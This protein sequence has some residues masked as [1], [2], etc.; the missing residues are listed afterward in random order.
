[1]RV[2]AIIT[3]CLVLC[4]GIKNSIAQEKIDWEEDLLYAKAYLEIMH[5]RLFDFVTEEEF[6]NEF[7]YLLNNWQNLND[8]DIITLITAIFVKIQDGHTGISLFKSNDYI[9]G[10]FHYYPVWLYRFNDGYFVLYARNEYKELVGKKITRLG[11]LGICDAISRMIRFQTGDNRWGRVQYIPLIHE[12]MQ[13]AGVIGRE[14]DILVFQYENNKGESQEFKIERP[15]ALKDFYFPSKVFP[16][17]DPGVYAMND[18][19]VKALPLYLSRISEGGFAGNNYWYTWLPEQGAIYLQISNNTDKPDDPFDTFCT[20]MF[21]D[22]D[23]LNAGK[24]IVDV[25]LNGG[26]SHFEMPL[27][28]GI[29]ARPDIDSKGNLF[30]I[31]G[32]RTISASEHLTTL[33]ET[34]TN[35]V[36]V[37]EPTAARP[38]MSGSITGFTLPNSG[39]NCFTAKEYIQ[40]SEF[41]DFRLTTEPHVFSLLSSD[42]YKNND[43]PVLN[44]IFNYDSISLLKAEC[45]KDMQAGYL[46]DGISGLTAAFH[47]HKPGCRKA[48]IN[49]EYLLIDELSGWMYSNRKGKEDYAAYIRFVADELP[50]SIRA[51]YW[52]GRNCQLNDKPDLAKEY[53]KRCLELNPAH[54]NAIKYSKL[55]DLSEKYDLINYGR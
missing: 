46:T 41:S 3:V 49:F 19:C 27:L 6:N 15:E 51:N 47:N 54:M 7:D 25:R 52:Y 40:D 21:H 17:K 38:N 29:I 23:S 9:K 32:R 33:M 30:L 8:A 53:Y 20:R 37:G 1:M 2:K 12:F 11:N 48:G 10:L 5:P 31:T 4:I 34:Y 13:C 55:I 35:V 44:A 50:E 28:K 26:G 14:S 16:Q 22:L 24:L 39:L 36:I 18:T 43:D 42:D 45:M